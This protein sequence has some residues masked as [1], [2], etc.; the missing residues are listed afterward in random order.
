MKKVKIDFDN[1]VIILENE[2]AYGDLLEIMD[3]IT[4]GEDVGD[5]KIRVEPIFVDK[6]IPIKKTS[7]PWITPS[8]TPSPTYPI[9]TYT[10]NLNDTKYSS[11]VTNKDK[12]NNIETT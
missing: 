4:D 6:L 9:I 12:N 5:W 11:G 7:N 1:K 3:I 2:I 8:P 10:Y